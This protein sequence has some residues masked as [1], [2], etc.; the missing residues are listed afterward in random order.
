MNRPRIQVVRLRSVE[1]GS[2]DVVPRLNGRAIWQG[3]FVCR[4]HKQGLLPAAAPLPRMALK[5]KAH[6]ARDPSVGT[7]GPKAREGRQK[8][9][10]AD[11]QRRGLL[12]P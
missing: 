2:D 5:P 6:R 10:L 1:V 4:V 12:A 7:C 3:F 8:I 11:L 9:D